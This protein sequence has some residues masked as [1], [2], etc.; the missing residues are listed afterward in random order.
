MMDSWYITCWTQSFYGLIYLHDLWYSV[1]PSSGE[2]WGVVTSPWTHH[3]TW[4]TSVPDR[5]T[6][7]LEITDQTLLFEPSW[8]TVFDRI[9]AS[10]SCVA[11]FFT[12]V[13]VL[14]MCLI[15]KD[16]HMALIFV[17]CV[18][19]SLVDN[20]TSFNRKNHSYLVL[21]CHN[22]HPLVVSDDLNRRGADCMHLQD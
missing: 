5:V 21:L 22:F 10:S 18:E 13:V 11:S 7:G 14:V 1:P 15:W 12:D 17:F 6:G 2:N 16:Q 4:W 20:W 3:Q 19:I 9:V 8:S